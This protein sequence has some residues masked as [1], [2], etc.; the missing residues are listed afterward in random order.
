MAKKLWPNEDA[1][2]KCVRVDAD[3][4]PC[5]TVVGIAED[6]RNGSI[7]ETQMHYYLPI[8]QFHPQDGGVFVE[9]FGRPAST[10]TVAA[11]LALKTGAPVLPGFI[12][13][14]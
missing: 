2:G 12:S 3:T 7:S 1:L 14:T 6:I 8:A 13:L 9:F 11:A 10:T 5:T 4:V